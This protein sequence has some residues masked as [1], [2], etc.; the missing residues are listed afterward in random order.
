MLEFETRCSTA[1]LAVG[2][3]RIH[4]HAV[5]FAK[6]AIRHSTDSPWRAAALILLGARPSQVFISHGSTQMDTA[7]SC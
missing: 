3:A 2:P 6:A 5:A 7:V 4:W 1:I